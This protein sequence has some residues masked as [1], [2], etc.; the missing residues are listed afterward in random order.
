MIWFHVLPSV[1]CVSI[2]P[3]GMAF[4]GEQ[5]YVSVSFEEEQLVGMRGALL[6]V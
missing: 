3:P 6:T 5:T 2:S 1:S 4:L